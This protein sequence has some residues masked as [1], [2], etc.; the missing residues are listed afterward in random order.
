MAAALSVGGAAATLSVG[1]AA[2]THSRLRSPPRIGRSWRRR[3]SE[4]I[5]A[6]R[7]AATVLP[8]DESD[9][10]LRS[11]LAA[12]SIRHRES[13]RPGPEFFYFFFRPN[14]TPFGFLF[15]L[16]V[17]LVSDRLLLESWL[18]R[19]K[20]ELFFFMIFCEFLRT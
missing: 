16:W 9:P 8:G 4:S 5:R 10:L 3:R 1:G 14:F 6:N 13:V 12:A 11:A 17:G 19:V 20:L 18:Q 15:D 7:I 2:A